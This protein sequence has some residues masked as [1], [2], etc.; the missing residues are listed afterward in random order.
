MITNHYLDISAA[1]QKSL[2]NDSLVIRLSGT[3]LTGLGYNNI[4]TDLTHYRLT[5]S[6]KMDTQ[7]VTL[8]IR[9]RFNTVESKYKGTGAGKDVRDRM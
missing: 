4:H 2:L 5:Q 1:I 7:R 9:Y 8:S 3:D 6:V